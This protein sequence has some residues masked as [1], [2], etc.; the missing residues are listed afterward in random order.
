MRKALSLVTATIALILVA[1]A[2]GCGG[3]SG[4][5]ATAPQTQS[6]QQPA[7]S[8]SGQD[9]AA[10]KEPFT[11]K[12]M[13][14]ASFDVYYIATQKG[15]AQKENLSFEYTGVLNIPDWIPSVVSGANDVGGQHMNANISAIVGGAPLKM[16]AAS[17]EARKDAPHATYW[18]LKDSPIKTAADLRNKKVAVGGFGTCADYFVKEYMRQNNEDPKT[19]ELLFLPD[20]QQQQMLD[21]R[22]ID[23]AGVHTGQ[24]VR[25]RASSDYRPLFSDYDL[26]PQ[27]NLGTAATF[28]RT[29]FIAKRPDVVR[30]YL[31]VIGNTYDWINANRDEAIQI[32]AKKLNVEP[33]FLQIMYFPEHALI[34]EEAVKSWLPIL[35]REEKIANVDL[36]KVYTNEFNPFFKK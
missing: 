24:D 25:F 28:F 17:T 19:L 14:P 31:G 22:K 8:A 5:N 34:K 16:V 23:V 3:A 4:Q 32:M 11:L 35:E 9:G 33:A 15:F 10:K 30:R 12:V 6:S 21:N 36:S 20:S 13:T 7:A 18:V 27:G 26:V 1:F 29:D 2:M